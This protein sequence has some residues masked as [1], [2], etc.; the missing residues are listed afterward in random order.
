MDSL[1]APDE[2]A[3]MTLN[4][5]GPTDQP[6]R[7]RAQRRMRELLEHTELG[8]QLADEIRETHLDLIQQENEARGIQKRHL[9]NRRHVLSLLLA[10]L[11]EFH[12]IEAE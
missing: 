3:T 11:D 2:G 7:K 6:D 9:G 12:G 10:A 8:P 5:N 4:G 1:S